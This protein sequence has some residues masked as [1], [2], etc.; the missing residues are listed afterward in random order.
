MTTK[1]YKDHLKDAMR[2]S[3]EN[4]AW[5][6][7]MDNRY[8]LDAETE[9]ELNKY[10]DRRNAYDV[11]ILT[12]LNRIDNSD[13][14]NMVVVYSEALSSLAEERDRQDNGVGLRTVEE[15]DADIEK[16]KQHLALVCEEIVI[17]CNKKDLDKSRERW[18]EQLSTNSAYYQQRLDSG[19][20]DGRKHSKDMH[21]YIVEKAKALYNE[22]APVS[23]RENEIIF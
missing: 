11:A 23:L 3:P 21:G 18:M 9:E 17:R 1:T 14:Y 22:I 19:A 16:Y 12:R 6:R 5:I 4:L 8:I 20:F 7:R 2:T 13:I 15:V 10:L